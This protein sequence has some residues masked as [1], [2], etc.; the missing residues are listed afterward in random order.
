METK[1]KNTN[2]E[3][4]KIKDGVDF[5]FEQHPKLSEIGTKEEYS[6]YLD[7]IFPESKIKDIVYHGT[8]KDFEEFDLEKQGKSGRNYGKGVYTTPDKSWATRGYAFG[9]TT[10]AII[11]NIKNPFFTNQTY[12]AW[13]GANYTI[14][15]EEKFTQYLEDEYDAILDYDD[16]DR[17]LLRKK[18]NT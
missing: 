8:D 7:Q 6:E 15:H 17:E 16:L 10:L 12:K 14:P 18:M 3:A 1:P 2:I 9:K 4:P 5:V 13:Y 11:V